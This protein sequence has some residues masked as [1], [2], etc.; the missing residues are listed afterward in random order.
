MSK[1]KHT[2]QLAFTPKKKRKKE[3]EMNVKEE[4]LRKLRA[5]PTHCQNGVK[6]YF[7]VKFVLQSSAKC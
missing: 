1:K 7:D 5:S 6:L 2:S 3:N 4:L